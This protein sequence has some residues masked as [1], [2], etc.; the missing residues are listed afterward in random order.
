MKNQ[1][2]PKSPVKQPKPA[3]SFR[4]DQALLD[5]ARAQGLD[6]AKLFEDALAQAVGAHKCPVCGS[7]LKGSK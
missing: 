4:I 7:K 1:K 3:R 6:V 2:K 5:E